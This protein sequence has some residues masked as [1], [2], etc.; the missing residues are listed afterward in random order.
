MYETQNIRVFMNQPHTVQ[1]ILRKQLI[2]LV[3]KKNSS[4]IEDYE[5]DSPR[6]FGL[7]VHITFTSLPTHNFY[8]LESLRR[9]VVSTNFLSSKFLYCSIVGI[10]SS[11]KPEM[12]RIIWK[13]Y[14]RCNRC[15]KKQIVFEPSTKR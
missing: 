9:H 1:Q 11:S 3:G 12:S 8:S 15:L 6:F 13:S 14:F 5:I 10:I 4:S 2:R 7:G